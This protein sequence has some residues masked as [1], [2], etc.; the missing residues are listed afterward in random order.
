VETGMKS[1]TVQTQIAADGKL[2]FDVATDLPAGP[3]E[4]VIVVH[5]GSSTEAGT[6]SFLREISVS[7][8]KPVQSPRRPVTV[9]KNKRLVLGGSA[10]ASLFVL[11]GLAA[12][13]QTKV[14]TL[15]V[16]A[17]EP[18]T[19]LQVLSDDGH[20]EIS[21]KGE[22][23]SATM[24]LVPGKHRLKVEKNGFE[25]FTTEFEIESGS[26]KSITAKLVPSQ[27]EQ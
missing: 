24:S 18:D 3:A 13:L 11:A 14:G 23:G 2:S 27:G 20:I 22:N 6:T 9:H 12:S 17:N 5:P 19:T 16:S 10:L 26:K 15:I 7:E 1:I 25:L 8:S 4:V 21:R